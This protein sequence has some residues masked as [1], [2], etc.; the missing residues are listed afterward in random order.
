M[1]H[2][3]V[4]AIQRLVA[5][6]YPNQLVIRINA[7]DIVKREEAT[8]EDVK[9]MTCPITINWLLLRILCTSS[10]HTISLWL[11]ISASTISISTKATETDQSLTSLFTSIPNTK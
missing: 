5:K 10:R 9:T 3:W 6:F 7:I 11:L 1:N 4:E 2:L 8:P